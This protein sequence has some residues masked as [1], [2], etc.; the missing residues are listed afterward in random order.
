[1]TRTDK[2]FASKQND[3][4]NQIWSIF[5]V[6]GYQNTT[7]SL[8]LKE[9]G[10]SK[11]VFYH[12]FDSKEHCAEAAVELYSNML[13]DKIIKRCQNNCIEKQIPTKKLKILFEQGKMLFIEN[14]ETLEGINSASNKIF[15]EMLMVALTK[16]LSILY[17]NIIEEGISQGQFHTSYPLE[18]A[19][20]FL[21]LSN[22]YLDK[23]F[24]YWKEKDLNNKINAYKE[25]VSK[26]LGVS[27]NDLF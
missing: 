3:L 9:L 18:F 14:S 24:F 8:I 20:M 4:L 23:N 13:I 1:M 17:Y 7:L 19:E 26:G 2:N 16:K 11:G 15:H 5:L 25:L 27:I 6:N 12:Y 21:A 10:I 22:F